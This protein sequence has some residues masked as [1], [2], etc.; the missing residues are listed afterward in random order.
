[1]NTHNFNEL[2]NIQS[3]LTT[4]RQFNRYALFPVSNTV[5][6]SPLLIEYFESPLDA[7]VERKVLSSDVRAARSE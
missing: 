7:K 4:L 3:A 1:M 6:D 2:S 5:F